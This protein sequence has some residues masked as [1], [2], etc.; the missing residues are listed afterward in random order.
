MRS[1]L[2]LP[3]AA[4]LTAGLVLAAMAAVTLII[5]VATTSLDDWSVTNYFFGAV[6]LFFVIG[7]LIA[8]IRGSFNLLGRWKGKT[9]MILAIVAVIAA[10]VVLA[11]SLVA[12][13]WD[14]GTILT[15]GLWA[16]LLVLFAAAAVE[17]NKK[18]KAGQ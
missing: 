4:A 13:E 12:D 3:L 6:I 14:Q 16:T 15:T 8:G 5:A 11:G 7:M 1:F 2:T 9:S 17:A 10:V 18:R